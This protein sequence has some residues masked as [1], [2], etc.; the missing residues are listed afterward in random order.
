MV[1]LQYS[2]ENISESNEDDGDLPE[3]NIITIH[4]QVIPLNDYVD[5]D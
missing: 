3:K 4:F 5:I 2:A 1:I